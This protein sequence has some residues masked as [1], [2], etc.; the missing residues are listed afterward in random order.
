MG[1]R[2]IT[3]GEKNERF[4]VL[5]L[6]AKES[7]KENNLLALWDE[8]ILL[9]PVDIKYKATMHSFALFASESKALIFYDNED[10]K[11]SAM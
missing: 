8:L 11:I 4:Q 3:A 7:I 6:A 10:D 5:F 9:C 1:L 2:M